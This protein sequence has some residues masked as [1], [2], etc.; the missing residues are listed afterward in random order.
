M[1]IQAENIVK[2]YG[3][4][5]VLNNF[6]ILIESGEFMA[7]MGESG[8]GKT[9]LVNILGLI[10]SEFEGV[11]KYD[12]KIVSRSSDKRQILKNDISF[13]FQ[14]Y[15]LIDNKTVEYNLSLLLNVKKMRKVERQEAINLA[16]S[17]VG[18]IDILDK[19]VYELSGGE[20]Q[21]VAL[22]KVFLKKPKLIIA[23]EPTASLDSENEK[24]V[25][26]YFNE[27]N[28][29]GCT[30]VVVTHSATVASYAKRTVKIE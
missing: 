8:C 25:M 7:L 2:K 30:I 18:L 5:V 11:V 13:I 22:S 23:D 4:R 21:R 26:Q 3:Q 17:K 16:L 12:G 20:Q 19:K 24:E 29:E 27:I 28:Q 10:D 1:K 6:N 9:T 14:N 15:G